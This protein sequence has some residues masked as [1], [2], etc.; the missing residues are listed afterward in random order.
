MTELTNEQVTELR[1]KH[2]WAKETIREI[3]RTILAAKPEP[4]NDEKAL[5]YGMR[6]AEAI[7]RK[8]YM[9]VSPHWRPFPDLLGVLTQVDNMT[10]RLVKAPEPQGDSAP[11]PYPD[12]TVPPDQYEQN[13]LESCAN[14]LVTRSEM[15][16]AG[17]EGGLMKIYAGD[18]RRI[19]ARLAEVSATGG[20]PDQAADS[21]A[22]GM[23]FGLS[24]ADFDKGAQYCWDKMQELQRQFS[25]QTEKVAGGAEP[26]APATGICKRCKGSGVVD[27]GEIDCSDGGIPFECGP[28]KCVKECPL[29]HG[30]RAAP[31]SQTVDAEE[32]SK[33]GRL[34]KRAQ[35]C[36]FEWSHRYGE[37]E[38]E[39]L[40]PSGDMELLDD[41][42]KALVS[43]GVQNAALKQGGAA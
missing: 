11:A 21:G 9:S 32:R 26:V 8:H 43:D 28:I 38:P 25:A 40:A 34:L 10:C 19:A 3:E 41:I 36:L 30:H 29:C 2:G 23:V 5:G 4:T 16:K 31:T 24:Q 22:V 39:W 37:F 1:A 35:N 6:L 33:Y 17:D 14:W 27:D 15:K 18:L 13:L 42:D 7:W 12:S 20:A